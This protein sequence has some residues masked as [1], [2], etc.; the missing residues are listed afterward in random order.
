MNKSSKRIA[1]VTGANK[2]I[3]LEIARQMAQSGVFVLV[4]ARDVQRGEVAVKNLS[5]SGLDVGFIQIDVVDP[6][7]VSAASE[8]IG[9]DYGRLD[10][11]VNNAGV[12]DRDDGAPGN[13]SLEAVR[14]IFDA[15]FFGPL[16]VTQAMLPLLRKSIAGRIINMSSSLGSLAMNDDSSSSFYGAPLFGYSAS[17]AVLNMMTIQ[18]NAE[19]RNSAIAV[20]SVCPGLTKTDMSDQRGNRS[21]EEAA[22][23]P[24]QFALADTV[25]NLGQFIDSN[26][27]LPW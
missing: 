17:K 25:Q 12:V 15:N 1:L 23:A 4:G 5:G 18:L 16:A 13:T 27:R 24:V 11:L 22:V 8:K 14:R 19:L 3:G 26:G 9:A 6:E 20:V 10:I 7:S 21:P 2:G